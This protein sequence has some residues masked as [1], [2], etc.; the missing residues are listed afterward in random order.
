M[1]FGALSHYN[2]KV[3]LGTFGSRG[4]IFEV[5]FLFSINSPFLLFSL[6]PGNKVHQCSVNVVIVN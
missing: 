3:A 2:M 6:I 5:S 4:G 1:K